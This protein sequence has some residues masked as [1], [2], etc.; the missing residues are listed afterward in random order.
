MAPV[1]NAKSNSLPIAIFG[2]Q[3]VLVT[4]LTANVLLQ[5][6][7][8]AKS[9]SPSTRTRL[10]NSIRR[11]NAI[12]FSLL[13][14]VSLASVGSFAFIWRAISYVR[15]AENKHY[16]TPNSILNGW[17]ATG[18]E[19]RW[20]LGDWI[21]DIDLVREF[22]SVGIMK[23]EGFLYTSQY[24]VGLLAAAIFMGAEG[25]RRNLS[26]STIASF[27]LLCSLGS[28]GF[29]LSLFF[30]TILYTPTTVRR[31]DSPK[32]DAFFTPSPMVYD[33]GIVVSLVTLNSFPELISE[34]GD[35]SMLRLSYLAMPLFFAFAPQIVPVSL[36]EQHTSKVAAHRSY[37]KVF[38]VLS[39][40]SLL[41]YWRIFITTIF[42]STPSKHTHVWDLFH[43]SH[44]RNTPNR[45]LA[46]I[47]IAGQRLKVIS[48]HPAISVTSLD[49]LFTTIALLTW[50]FT[51]DLDVD[52]LLESSVF[53]F[54]A[55]SHEKRV[56][57]KDD[58]TRLMET[59][60]AAPVETTTPKKRG[61]PSKSA[62]AAV[63]G[64]SSAALAVSGSLRRSSRRKAGSGD[65]DTE[66]LARGTDHDS[67]G[68]LTYQPSEETRQAV[69][70]TEADGAMV[71]GD[72]VH[73]G[74]STAL[75]LFF[76]MMGGVGQLASA[77]LGAEVTG[78]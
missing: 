16:D 21:S 31:D 59:E 68:D 33:L 20:H 23:P 51:R 63:N 72:V 78:P 75:A 56:N 71:D 2:G 47:S 6:R 27:V 24:F 73:A 48:K 54:L 46:G 32:H 38:Y 13:A 39:L 42:M 4:V 40:A 10:Q 74:E 29:S 53:S 34:Y 1:E 45:V 50:T 41:L 61:R 66:P 12:V 58:L 43:N 77:V 49:V 19:A 37:A 22:D 64:V 62:V 55:S 69:A 8:A 52:Y 18:T 14:A 28:L 11:R 67:D 57:F 26:T 36:G 76:A 35:K 17:S 70:E 5:A 3:I 65:Y 44:G 30:V 25:R 9:L 60:P 7:R 15:W